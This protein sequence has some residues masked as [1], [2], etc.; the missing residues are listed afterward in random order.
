MLSFTMCRGGI[1]KLWKSKNP[2][3]E[4][5]LKNCALIIILQRSLGTIWGSQIKQIR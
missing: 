2:S 4:E 1:V 3:N 5:D